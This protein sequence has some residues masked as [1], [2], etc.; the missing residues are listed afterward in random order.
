MNYLA[1]L[2]LSRRDKHSI[3]GN[4]MGDFRRHLNGS[5]LPEAVTDGI[6]NHQ[7]VDKFTDGHIEVRELKKYF[8]RK[9]RRFAG[10]ILDLA[11]DHFLAVHWER[12]STE[13]R[14]EFIG[15]CYTCLADGMDLMPERMQRIVNYM[16]RE[17]W[18]ASYRDLSG[19]DIALNRLSRRI[20]FENYLQGAIEE[21][22][23][24]YSLIET[25]FLA[26]FPELI[27]YIN[28]DWGH[29]NSIPPDMNL[30]GFHF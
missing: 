18:L 23:S 29:I 15:Y 30:E 20:R 25:G 21:V 26:F 8:S 3:I 10:I 19:I 24:N 2:R 5:L 14:D 16:I 28:N 27:E 12:Y 6:E 11:F 22:E 9:R 17:N 1:H 13:P 7:R 4:L